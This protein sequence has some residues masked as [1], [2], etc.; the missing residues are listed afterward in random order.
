MNN[1]FAQQ[2]RQNLKPL[3]G[4]NSF[5]V[6]EEKRAEEEGEAEEEEE[7]EVH[8]EEYAEKRRESTTTSRVLAARDQNLQQDIQQWTSKRSSAEQQT[9][10]YGSENN[11]SPFASIRSS[12]NQ[13]ESTRDAPEHVISQPKVF[14]L[15]RHGRYEQLKQLIEGKQIPIESRESSTGNT[16]LIIGAQNNLKRV[17]KLALR[18]RGNSKCSRSSL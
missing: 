6:H 13:F 12:R 8:G 14:S 5:T 4:N 10:N 17:V 7:E 2:R 1:P 3:L 11:P 16:I 15:A 9:S 18:N